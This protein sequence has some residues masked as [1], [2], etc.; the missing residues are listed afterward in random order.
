MGFFPCFL[1]Y[2]FIYK[3]LAGHGAGPS[4]VTLGSVAAAIVGLQLGAFGVVAE[5]V[6]SGI[7]ELPFKTFLLVMQPIHLAIGIVEGL[8]TAAVVAFVW[9]VRPEILAAASTSAPI[10]KVV[11][12]KVLLVLGLLALITGGILSWFASGHPD[13]LEW[14]MF[15]VSGREELESPKGLHETAAGIQERTAFLPDYAFKQDAPEAGAEPSVSWPA[16]DPG[17][18]VSGLVGGLLTLLIAGMLGWMLKRR[19]G[20]A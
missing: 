6:L 3:K 2:P 7:T 9:K 18:S 16:V 15:K 11:I 1:C 14:S 12:K 5:T 17:T 13:G 4:A 8:I 20:A 19:R 10:G